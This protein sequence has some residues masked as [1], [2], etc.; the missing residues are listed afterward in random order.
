E[1]LLEQL[2]PR[3]GERGHG[4]LPLAG[5]GASGVDGAASA[6]LAL[7]TST[8]CGAIDTGGSGSGER[9]ITVTAFAG[10]WGELFEESF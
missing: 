3:A 5:P 7:L 1:G 9:E 2:A 8:A 10:P 6:V 4:D